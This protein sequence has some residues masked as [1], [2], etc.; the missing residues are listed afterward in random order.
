ML[1]VDAGSLDG[2]TEYLAGVV[3]GAA[4]V[5][6]EVLR[7]ASDQAFPQL[8]M[9]ALARAR[10]D[11]IAWVNNDVL[12]PE[13]WLEQ[14]LALAIADDCIGVVGPM[15]NIAPGKQRVAAIP[16]RLTR[17]RPSNEPQN[18]GAPILETTGVDH[19]AQ[20]F[21]QTNRGQWTDLEQIGGFC[22]LG[23]NEVLRRIELLN[24]GAENGVFDGAR[25]SASVRRAGYRLACCRDL[26]VHHFG[27]NLREN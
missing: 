15:A 12:V 19:Y 18:P 16:Y 20:E 4:S 10:G 13:F 5:E 22:W 2:T 24:K 3:A 9:Q 23:K 25:F 14:L 7:V 26:Y 17:P 1:F 27:A 6:I 8:V 21:R 11:F